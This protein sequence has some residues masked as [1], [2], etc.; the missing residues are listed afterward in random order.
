[1]PFAALCA[2]LTESEVLLGCFLSVE[3]ENDS[4]SGSFPAEEGDDNKSGSDGGSGGGGCG[5][6]DEDFRGKP[7]FLSFRSR[8]PSRRSSVAASM[9]GDG[10]EVR[11]CSSLALDIV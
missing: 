11:G 8:S 6:G 10:G 2:S 5:G 7:H 9:A 1:M 3:E 4:K